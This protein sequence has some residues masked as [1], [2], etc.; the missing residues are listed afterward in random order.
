MGQ[1]QK[2]VNTSMSMC[3]NVT[4]VWAGVCERG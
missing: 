1:S 2:F 4:G 3:V